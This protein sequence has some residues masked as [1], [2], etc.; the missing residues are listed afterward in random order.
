MRYIRSIVLVLVLVVVS[1]SGQKVTP[2]AAHLLAFNLETHKWEPLIVTKDTD[3]YVAGPSGIQAGVVTVRV[4]GEDKADDRILILPPELVPTPESP[5][6][7][8]QKAPVPAP[9]SQGRLL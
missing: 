9:Q 4:P 7:A 1:A 3:I 6:P 5:T 8:P 2:P